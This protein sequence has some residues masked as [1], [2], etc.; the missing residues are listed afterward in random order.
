MKPGC[1]GA[2]RDMLRYYGSKGDGMHH[3]RIDGPVLIPE[4][5]IILGNGDLSVSVYQTTDRIVWKFGKSDVWD[6]RLDLSDDPRPAHISE[7]A[8]GI[9]EEGWKCG[10]YGGPVEAT[11]GTADPA[12]MEE[13]CQGAPPSYHERPYPCPKPV[14]ELSMY[15]P[16]DQPGLQIVQDLRIEEGILIIKCEW[17]AAVSLEVR[18]FIHPVRN[19]LIVSWNLSGWEDANRTGGNLPPIRFALYRWADPTV[20]EFKA[21]FH[22]DYRHTLAAVGDSPVVTPLSAPRVLGSE[23]ALT[24]EQDF[25]AEVTFP[26]GFR[27]LVAATAPACTQQQIPMA[28]TGE[29]RIH[30]LPGID[31]TESWVAVCVATT[32]DVVGPETVIADTRQLLSDSDADAYIRQ[33]ESETKKAGDEFWSRSSLSVSDPLLE[34]LWYQT[35]HIRRSTYRKD[36]W[37]P[38]LFLPSTVQDYSHWHGDY[39]TNYNFQ[40][41]FWGDGTANHPELADAF[42]K[43]MEHFMLMGRT[44]AEKFYHARG[45]FI[46][47][48]GYPIRSTQDCLCVVPMGRMAYM[49][50]WIPEH[51]WS[52]Y[53]LTMDLDWLAGTGYP[54]IRDCALFYTD[55]LQKGPDYLYHAFP[56]NQGEDGF[57]GD[58]EDYT[59]RAM[60]MRYARY[61]LNIAILASVELQTDDALRTEWTT[62]LDGM[63][64]DEGDPTVSADYYRE[65][66]DIACPPHLLAGI[67]HDRVVV[68]RTDAADAAISLLHDR[69]AWLWRWYCGK[70]PWVWMAT[71]RDRVFDPGRDLPAIR[72]LIKRWR[73]TN[74]LLWAMSVANYG[75]AGAWTESLGIIAPLQ[76]MMLQSWDG[77]VRLFPACPDELDVSFTDWRAEGAFLVSASHCGGTVSNVSIRSERGGVCTVDVPWSDGMIVTHGDGTETRYHVD[78]ADA[79]ASFDTTP[80]ET[81]FLSP[82][83]P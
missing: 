54:A 8:K 42:F 32:S 15:L 70:L 75:H 39:H 80:G 3:I 35:L 25:P 7:I 65:E 64:P 72:G 21:R 14:G 10:P 30:L 22:G 83:A 26:D 46:Q 38:G 76:E 33:W 2:A 82:P 4:D 51:Y 17:K 58:P 61:C 40:Q 16:P 52:R 29:A 71:L 20:A 24:I 12:R 73:H 43:G 19:V 57:T 27:C 68:G 18:C 37:P 9:R 45:V 56:S 53:R 62:I 48:T 36:V 13:L 49:T 1:G 59:D 67:G 69:T 23:V 60:V 66:G 44:I 6:R 55:F 50:G 63:A 79:L 41:P 31:V 77:V 74:G 5:G 81:L 34:N 28:E 47:L 11:K 78:P